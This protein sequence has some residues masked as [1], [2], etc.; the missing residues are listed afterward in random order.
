MFELTISWD[1]A[2]VGRRS[3]IAATLSARL[4]WILSAMAAFSISKAALEWL[5]CP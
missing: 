2:A 5:E 1:S 3:I 4:E